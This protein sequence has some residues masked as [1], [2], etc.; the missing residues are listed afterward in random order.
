M[1]RYMLAMLYYEDAGI[2][3]RDPNPGASLEDHQDF[4]AQSR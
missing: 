2:T 1:R 4:S 3:N